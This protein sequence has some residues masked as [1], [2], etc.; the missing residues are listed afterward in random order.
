[1]VQEKRDLRY[2]YL[3]ELTPIHQLV[4]LF[5]TR[6]DEV[7]LPPDQADKA[8][9]AMLAFNRKENAKVID[10]GFITRVRARLKLDHQQAAVVFGEDSN[11][12]VRYEAGHS[13]PSPALV[14]LLQVLDKHPT[15][16]KDILPKPAA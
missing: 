16:L 14:K 6:C 9:K 3:G 12:F 10:P 7:I 8:S 2:H 1:M 5:C 15:F 4:G 13:R 11:A